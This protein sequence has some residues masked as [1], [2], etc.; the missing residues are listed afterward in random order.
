MDDS[1]GGSG[2]L[3]RLWSVP[4][5]WASVLVIRCYQRFIS[6]RLPVECDFEPSCS[7]FAV[8]AF[9]RHGFIEGFRLTWRR[10]QRCDGEGFRGADYPPGCEDP[11][12]GEG[13]VGEDVNA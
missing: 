11:D 13:A 2:R 12:A 4:F 3:R 7:Q 8:L 1:R 6:S 5:V 9:R 10:L